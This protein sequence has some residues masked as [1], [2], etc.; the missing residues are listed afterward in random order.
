MTLRGLLWWLALVPL[1][2]VM[3]PQAL[4]AQR[5]TLRLPVAGGAR[6]GLVGLGQTGRPLRLRVLGE[7]TVV[8][9]GVERLEDGLAAQV[10]HCLSE[11]FSRQVHWRVAG[12]S[13]IRLAE[14]LRRLP[15]Q[16]EEEPADLALL[17]LGVN[18]TLGLSGRRH[19]Q[20]GLA[21]LIDAC[22]GEN[23]RVLLAGVPPVGH[24]RALPWPLRR[25]FGWRAALLDRWARQVAERK[26]ALHLPVRLSFEPGFLARDG[27]HPSAAGYRRWAQDMLEQYLASLDGPRASGSRPENERAGV[28][29]GPEM[30]R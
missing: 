21:Q 10:A 16:A 9:V 5:T 29:A 14:L 28:M 11:R 30:R 27:F 22:A 25:M 15:E 13:G 23:T 3:L 12:E 1:A 18:D 7:S 20:Q 17:V 24:F 2:P 6:E 26:G 19:W 8:G 4:Y